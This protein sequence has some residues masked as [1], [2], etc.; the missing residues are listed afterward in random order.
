MLHVASVCTPYCFIV[1]CCW[2]L[3]RKV[4]N[5]HSFFPVIAEGCATMLDLF[6]QLFPTLLGPHTP[7]THGFQSLMGCIL[8]TMHCRSQHC[9]ELLHPFAHHCKHGHNNSHHCWPNTNNVKSCY[10]RLFVALVAFK[11]FSGRYN[12][13]LQIRRTKGSR[14]AK[15]CIWKGFFRAS[16]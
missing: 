1:T 12:W 2:E 15:K 5:Q 14:E 13:S 6:A 7:I 11:R 3:L 9:W 4:W 8:L 16:W 10:V